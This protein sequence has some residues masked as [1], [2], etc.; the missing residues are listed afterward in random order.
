[1]KST[2]VSGPQIIPI[3]TATD[4]RRLLNKFKALVKAGHIA[5]VLEMVSQRDSRVVTP[6]EW[7]IICECC[8]EASLY[9][10]IDEV[11]T[12]WRCGAPFA[13]LLPEY[14]NHKPSFVVFGKAIGASG[15]AIHWDGVH[16]KRL[17]YANP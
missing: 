11:L 16:V 1:M 5:V 3:S 14:S 15:L 6:Q 4:K 7:N 8:E 2:C 10:A 9:L 12:V 13:H 17:G